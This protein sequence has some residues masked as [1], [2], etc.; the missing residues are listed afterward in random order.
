MSYYVL[1]LIISLY[2]VKFSVLCTVLS[3]LPVK[4]SEGVYY[5]T[6]VEEH[7]WFLFED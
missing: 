1:T 4:I 2:Q 3:Y 5:K 7:Q 6:N